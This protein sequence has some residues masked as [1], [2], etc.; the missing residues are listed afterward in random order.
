MKHIKPLLEA[1]R[2]RSLYILGAGASAPIV[3]TALQLK[4]S[5]IEAVESLG[6]YS[7]SP[8]TQDELTKKIIGDPGEGF[9]LSRCPRGFLQAYN[10]YE[11]T[12]HLHSPILFDNIYQYDIFNFSKKPSIIFTAN[13]DALAQRCVGHLILPFH[14]EIP[15]HW[16]TEEYKTIIL[17]TYA[18]TDELKL[19]IPGLIFLE[20]E[21]TDI[22]NTQPY[23][24]LRNNFHF[25]RFIVVIGFSF[26]DDDS[27][28]FDYLFRTLYKKNPM[29]IIV[30]S[31]DTYDLVWRIKDVIEDNC[32]YGI[33]DHWD[34]LSREIYKYFLHTQPHRK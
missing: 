10:Y 6:T 15:P 29:P 5:S 32:V 14:G 24:I 30:I 13:H 31:P 7:A 25:M 2:H 21:K 26:A 8:I 1:F 12:K 9:C 23:V 22:L 28:T 20:K 11:L 4:Q 18:F 27:Q 3:P 16:G 34:I 19:E 33:N 17:D